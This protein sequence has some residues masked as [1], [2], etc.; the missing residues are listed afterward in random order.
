MM[1]MVPVLAGPAQITFMAFV[2][3][4]LCSCVIFYW[5]GGEGKLLSY[6]DLFMRVEGEFE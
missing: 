2:Y 4:A 6:P 1:V 5:W 3:E